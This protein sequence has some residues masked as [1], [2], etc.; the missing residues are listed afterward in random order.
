MLTV[1]R[2]HA[3][4]QTYFCVGCP[5]RQIPAYIMRKFDFVKMLEYVER[6]RITG[7]TLVPPIAVALAK[8][9]RVS[10]Y[11]LSSVISVGCGAAPLGNEV[12][13]ELENKWP[14]GVVNVKQGWGMTEFVVV[15]YVAN[16]QFD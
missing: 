13:R 14:P 6:Y 5:V 11:D 3:Y 16:F 4:G 10:G 12:S 15:H 1:A 2:Y 9:A 8:D 7:L